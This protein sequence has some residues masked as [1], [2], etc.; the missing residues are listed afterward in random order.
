MLAHFIWLILRDMFRY[1]GRRILHML[2]GHADFERMLNKC[3]PSKSLSPT[4]TIIENLR[5]KVSELF[6]IYLQYDLFYP[7]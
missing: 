2:D 1:Y 3:L 5:S 6:D 4:L 7:C